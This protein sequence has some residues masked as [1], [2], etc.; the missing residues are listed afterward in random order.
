M[1]SSFT[2]SNCAGWT[3]TLATYYDGTCRDLVR[4]SGNLTK[5]AE[6]A[7]TI[8]AYCNLGNLGT[9]GSGNVGTVSSYWCDAN[10]GNYLLGKNKK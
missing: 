3:T 9:G 1:I 10:A 5:A 4:L 2:S 8:V 7:S 6:V